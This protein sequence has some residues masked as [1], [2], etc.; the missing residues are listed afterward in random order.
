MKKD[1]INKTS[2]ISVRMTPMERMLIESKA[3]KSGR[4]MSSF[5][6]QSAMGIQMKVL[7]DEEKK[8]YQD[9]ANYHTN[10]SRI[11]NLFRKGDH[12]KMITELEELIQEIKEQLKII[13]N[14]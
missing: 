14:G 7:S 3:K 1:K 12:P 5:M 10:F 9:L 2:Q 11:G 4:T 8:A 13:R 6:V